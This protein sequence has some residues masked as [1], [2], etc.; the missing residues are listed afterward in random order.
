M[1]FVLEGG[2]RAGQLVDDL[3]AGYR[4]QGGVHGASAALFDDVFADVAVWRGDRDT[5]AGPA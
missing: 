3:P 4:A 2:P 5:P 1:V